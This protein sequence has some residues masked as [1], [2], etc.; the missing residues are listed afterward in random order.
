M[1]LVAKLTVLWRTSDGVRCVIAPYDETRFQ[2]R[3]MR[4][5][6]TVKSDL[7]VD[8]TQALAA[9]REWRHRVG[10]VDLPVLS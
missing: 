8:Y 6:G 1:T 10:G 3:L 5:G 2:L 9:S 4:D 7:F